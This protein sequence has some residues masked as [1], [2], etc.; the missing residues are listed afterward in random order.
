M[1]STEEVAAAV[2]IAFIT[3]RRRRRRN[4]TQ[5]VKRW[6]SRRRNYGACASLMNELQVEDPMQL[7]NFFRLY[8]VEIEELVG[9]IGPVVQKQDTTVRMILDALSP[10]LSTSHSR[11][12]FLLSITLH[13]RFPFLQSTTLVRF[14]T[15]LFEGMQKI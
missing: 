4:R 11:F 12:A 14:G 10:A 2:A 1:S 7:R 3:K 9:W 13:S 8:A 15:E 6:L 5:W